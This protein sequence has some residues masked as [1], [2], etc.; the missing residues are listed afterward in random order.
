MEICLN[1][2]KRKKEIIDNIVKEWIC[3]R[4]RLD[5][6]QLYTSQM[7]TCHE[8]IHANSLV[9]FNVMYHWWHWWC[10][11]NIFSFFL[12]LLLFTRTK[13]CDKSEKIP[14]EAE[15]TR[16]WCRWIWIVLYANRDWQQGYGKYT[17]H[18]SGMIVIYV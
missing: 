15:A 1:E 3:Y 16:H 11:P 14:N 2:I 5:W 10:W 4:F 13:L 12:F 6:I 9:I 17:T 8:I 7:T 18:I